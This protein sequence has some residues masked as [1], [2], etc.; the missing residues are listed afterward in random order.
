MVMRETLDGLQGG[1]SIGGRMITNL[2]YADNVILLASAEAEL[3]DRLDRVK[4]KKSPLINVDKTKV[5]ASDS[6]ASRIIIQNEQ[7]EQV[8]TFAIPIPWVPDYRR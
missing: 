1:L 8:D 3:Q 4:R 2:R 7:L 5:M 6:I